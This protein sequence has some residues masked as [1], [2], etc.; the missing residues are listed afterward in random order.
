[1]GVTEML[2]WMSGVTRRDKM[3]ENKLKLLGHVLKREDV[4]AVSGVKGIYVERNR[5]KG[6][7]K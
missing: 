2:E 7:L 3:K 5:G 1:M 6:W 4:E